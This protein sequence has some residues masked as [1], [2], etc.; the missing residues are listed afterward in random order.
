M[1]HVT[2]VFKM[3]PRA[4]VDETYKIA[5]YKGLSKLTNLLLERGFFRREYEEEDLTKHTP[6]SLYWAKHVILQKKL[7]DSLH[8]KDLFGHLYYQIFNDM[9]ALGADD[10]MTRKLSIALNKMLEALN[11]ISLAW[12][13]YIGENNDQM[14]NN[15]EYLSGDDDTRKKMDSIVTSDPSKILNSINLNTIST[16]IDGKWKSALGPGIINLFGMIHALTY[17][18][19]YELGN[20]A[21]P[22]I[23]ERYVRLYSNMR[24]FHLFTV[25]II[26]LG[27]I[28]Q[29]KG[30]R[31]ID[32]TIIFS[33]VLNRKELKDYIGQFIDQGTVFGLSSEVVLKLNT[34]LKS[35]PAKTIPIA[36]A[37]EIFSTSLLGSTLEME[38]TRIADIRKSVKGENIGSGL[39]VPG[40]S[41]LGSDLGTPPASVINNNPQLTTE[42]INN[43]PNLLQSDTE[44]IESPSSTDKEATDTETLFNIEIVVFLALIVLVALFFL[45][46]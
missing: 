28:I 30:W 32:Y 29:D 33:D 31:I 40:P 7:I 39:I 15:I 43:D 12:L 41:N 46:R 16:V 22:N 11:D 44:D 6:D 24:V 34:E 38:D 10:E 17:A 13:K 36:K 37:M 9:R 42:I 2:K 5:E 3:R 20:E 23:I 45:L 4:P 27:R 26:D 8:H 1:E 21:T 19:M 14:A 25:F 35:F 18:K